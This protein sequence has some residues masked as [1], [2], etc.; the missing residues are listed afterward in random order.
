MN[1]LN[2]LDGWRGLAISMVLISH[3][4]PISGL[5]FGRMG[6]DIFFVLS[7][8]LMS[9][10]LFVKRTP[11][12]TFYRRRIAR[13]FPVF[14]FFVL[15][16]YSAI[17]YL[18][19]T[20][21]SNILYT[22]AFLRTYLPAS[23]GIWSTD[24]PIGHMWSLNVEEHLYV[25]MSTI[26]LLSIFRGREWVILIGLGC[27]SIVFKYWYIRTG[28][29]QLQTEA[30]ASHLLLS[31]GY[32]LV[33][34]KIDTSPWIVLATLMAGVWCYSEYSPWFA[35]WTLA[36]FLFAYTVNHLDALHKPLVKA[37][38]FYPV[39][40]LGLWSFSIYIWQQPFY[41]WGVKEGVNSPGL[42]I[43]AIITGWL[44]FKLIEQP[45]RKYIN[46]KP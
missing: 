8:M 24:V 39:R 11:L 5:Q 23:P 16:L 41:H 44:S 18:G 46:A 36:P 37:L 15:T 4:F 45:A 2:Y 17:W 9:Q 13:V 25:L 3:F 20:E 27:A 28:G 42:L 35:S 19:S 22:L 38:E 43:A 10:I 34:H 33:K 31:A 14:I 6:V 21:S 40:L 29:N 26:T 12:L 7:G 1:R 32:F 30:V